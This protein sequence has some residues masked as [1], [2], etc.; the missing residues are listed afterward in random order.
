MDLMER[1]LE[2]VIVVTNLD[3]ERA[4][5]LRRIMLK[6]MLFHVM[7]EYPIV[8]HEYTDVDDA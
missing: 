5:E 3:D 4:Q 7:E 1:L 8:M 6:P 2:R